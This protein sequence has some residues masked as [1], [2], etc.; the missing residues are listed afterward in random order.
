[1]MNEGWK[2]W[3]IK[4][5]GFGAGFALGTCGPSN[6]AEPWKQPSMVGVF[7]LVVDGQ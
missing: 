5:A 2:K 3:L 4:S 1:V 7:A 6:G